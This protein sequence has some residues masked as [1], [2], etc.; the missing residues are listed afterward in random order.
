[1]LTP[2]LQVLKPIDSSISNSDDYE[3]FILSNARVYYTANG[4]PANLLVA[5]VDTPL[6]VEGRLENPDKSQQKYCKGPLTLSF[7]RTRGLTCCV[8][9]KRPFRPVEIEI[10][11]VMRFSY[12]QTEDGEIVIWALGEA[13]WFEINPAPA[14]KDTFQD[15]LEAV[16]L[17]YFILDVHQELKKGKYPSTELLFQEVCVC[18]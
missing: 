18:V 10:K 14:Y 2:E 3:I 5:H 6:R 13:G 15:M 12:G 16:Q 9:L 8:V 1:M 17:W 4:K 11:N 7:L